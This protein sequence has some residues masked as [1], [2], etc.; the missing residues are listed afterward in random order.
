MWNHRQNKHGASK[1][2]DTFATY[3]PATG[4]STHT[5]RHCKWVNDLK[6]NPEAGYKRARKPRPRGKGGKGKKEQ[7]AAGEDM[8][9]DDATQDAEE[10]TAAK[11]GNPWAKKSA[12]AYHTF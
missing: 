10:G 12:G 6:S 1:I 2:I 11:S 9:E 4:K 5:N 3:H 8:D 7:D